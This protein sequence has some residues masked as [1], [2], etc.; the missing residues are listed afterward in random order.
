MKEL[1]GYLSLG[2]GTTKMNDVGMGT[3]DE[4]TVIAV[5]LSLLSVSLATIYCVRV[6]R[7]YQEWHDERAAVSLAKALGLLVISSGLLV[8]SIGLIFN[9]PS[10]S[11]AGLSIARGT[12]IVL[13]ATLVLAD[14]R[15]HSR[16]DE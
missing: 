5:F 11:I 14:V 7:A 15:P 6:I 2:K 1:S 3:S 12:F 10:F 9:S 8:S 13:M 16:S 4:Y